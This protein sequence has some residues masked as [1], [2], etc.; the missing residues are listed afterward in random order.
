MYEWIVIAKAGAVVG[1]HIRFDA[2]L[3]TSLE[4]FVG[5]SPAPGGSLR[6]NVLRTVGSSSSCTNCGSLE[7]LKGTAIL[8][9]H[10]H[11]TSSAA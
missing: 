1:R 9:S 3:E 8:Y 11:E 4:N 10:V 5:S 2:K 6:G 7:L